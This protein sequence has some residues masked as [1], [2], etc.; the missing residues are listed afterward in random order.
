MTSG[1]GSSTPRNVNNEDDRSSD[2]N[3]TLYDNICSEK[4][5]AL[6]SIINTM[7]EGKLEDNPS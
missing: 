4:K 3:V 1:E 2:P 7:S 6:E 5:K